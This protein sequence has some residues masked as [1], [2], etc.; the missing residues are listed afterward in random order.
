MN[1]TVPVEPPPSSNYRP[2]APARRSEAAILARAVF[3]R[4]RDLLNLLPAEAYRLKMGKVP[5]G[6]R[7][8]W[9]VNDPKL[10][11]RILVEKA[12]D[13]PKSDLMVAALKPL[14]GDGIFISNSVHGVRIAKSLLNQRLNSSPVA[15]KLAA[16]YDAALVTGA[17]NKPEDD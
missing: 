1:L 12:E 9:I 8:I 5:I 13:Y 6:K 3:L 17:L 11:R 14:V 10:I 16:A 7:R 4:Q 15:T 2:P